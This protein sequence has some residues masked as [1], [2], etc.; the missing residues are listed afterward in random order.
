MHGAASARIFGGSG[1]P[2]LVRAVCRSLGIGP[3]ARMV[4]TFENDNLFVRFDDDLCG[5]DVFLVQSFGRPV[6]THIMEL[7]VMADAARRDGAERITAVLPYFAYGR[8]DSKSGAGV[9]I[10]ARLVADLIVAAGVERVVT[11]DL[12]ASQIQGF[13]D[14]P[15]DELSSLELFAA[16]FLDGPSDRVVVAPHEG[17]VR[18]A[19]RLAERMGL[20]LA[21]LVRRGDNRNETGG[22]ERLELLGDVSGRPAL[23]VENEIASAYSIQT[24]A[25]RLLMGGAT[26]VSV[27][28]TH[29]V[30][31]RHAIRRLKDAPMR[32][33]VVTDT[34]STPS[35]VESLQ[36]T[37]VSVAPLL[38]EAIRRI[39]EH[40]RLDDLSDGLDAHSRSDNDV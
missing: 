20:S 24:A 32:E 14:F 36:I 37:T 17:S 13:F 40:R 33:L 22:S 6:N 38:G 9:P 4:R 5:R 30:M 7:L 2:A 12:H 19:K 10:T 15:V 23:L 28:A 8:T 1:N 39:H 29:A 31:S 35:A 18:W 27:A 25:E 26:A 34:L 11:I 16:H 21:I 3:G